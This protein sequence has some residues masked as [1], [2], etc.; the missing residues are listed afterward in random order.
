MSKQCLKSILMG[1]LL[2]SFSNYSYSAVQT[3]SVESIAIVQDAR[4]V[5]VC[6]NYIDGINQICTVPGDVYCEK[7]GADGYVNLN[8][9][10]PSGKELYSSILAAG[11]AKRNIQV[12]LTSNCTIDT[13]NVLMK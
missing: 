8:L 1:L 4:N 10:M 7:A 11:V 6:V 2:S 12:N 3:L 5:R 9:E 13:V